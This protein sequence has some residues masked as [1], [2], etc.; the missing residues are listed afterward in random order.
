MPG[1]SAPAC[2]RRPKRRNCAQDDQFDPILTAAK[3]KPKRQKQ[4]SPQNL[5]GGHT[6]LLPS[7]ED[8][9][10]KHPTAD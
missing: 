7:I 8:A 2:E 3:K 9:L 1:R 5:S 4:P 10:L 6:I